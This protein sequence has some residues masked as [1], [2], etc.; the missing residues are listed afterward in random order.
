MFEVIEFELSKP[1]HFSV[2]FD[3]GIRIDHPMLIFANPKETEIPD[4]DA[5]GVVYFGAGVHEIGSD[6]SLESDQWFLIDPKTT[7]RIEFY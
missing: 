2:E 4:P 1:G 3:E 7:Q 5:P 6:Y